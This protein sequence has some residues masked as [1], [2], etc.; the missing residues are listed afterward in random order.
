MASTRVTF[1][2]IGPG[3]EITLPGPRMGT[4]L[5][6]LPQWH[7]LEHGNGAVDGFRRTLTGL[8]KWNFDL[9]DLFAAD[10]ANIEEFYEAVD[11]NTDLWEYTHTDD[12]VYEVRFWAAPQYKR[13]GSHLY[14]VSIVLLCHE[15]PNGLV[16]A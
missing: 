10:Y 12:R 5:A 1:A 14:D 3:L 7:A 11:G 9:L 13:N 4:P 15:E 6:Q 2:E 8:W 16:S